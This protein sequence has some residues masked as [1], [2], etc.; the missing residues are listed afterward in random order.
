MSVGPPMSLVRVVLALVLAARE[1]QHLF[2]QRQH[3]RIRWS[4]FGFILRGRV[5]IGGGSITGYTLP[6]DCMSGLEFCTRVTGEEPALVFYR[7]V[8]LLRRR[9]R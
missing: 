5:D 8:A 6:K 2:R 1:L 9:S 3:V 7:R 4:T